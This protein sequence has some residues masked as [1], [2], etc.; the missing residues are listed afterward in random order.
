MHR[1]AAHCRDVADV[2]GDGFVR[3][4]IGRVQAADEVRIFRDEIRT[5]DDGMRRRKIN[6]GR[7]IADADNEFASLRTESLADL[8]DQAAFPKLLKVHAMASA[9]LRRRRGPRTTLG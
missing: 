5:E 7:I 1:D 9:P 2:C 3:D 4:R 6:D 8:A